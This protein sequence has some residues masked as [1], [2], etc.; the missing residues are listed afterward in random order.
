MYTKTTYGHCFSSWPAC[1]GLPGGLVAVFCCI[2]ALSF[3][4]MS[5]RLIVTSRAHF[6]LLPETDI[7]FVPIVQLHSFLL[8]TGFAIKPSCGSRLRRIAL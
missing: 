8:G 4:L 7:I 3:A 5:T 1:E 2:F 6:S